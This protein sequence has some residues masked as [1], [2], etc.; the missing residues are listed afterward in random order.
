MLELGRVLRVSQA[1]SPHFVDHVVMWHVT[2]GPLKCFQICVC[3]GGGMES[4]VLQ[5]Q[6]ML[7]G[8]TP[9]S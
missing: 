2:G 6:T 7:A 9:R 3:L 1:K 4:P 8:Q 5:V